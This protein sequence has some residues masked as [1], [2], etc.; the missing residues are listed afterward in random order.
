MGKGE[1][2]ERDERWARGRETR[3]CRKELR[4]I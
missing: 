4:I 2:E 1:R 3:G